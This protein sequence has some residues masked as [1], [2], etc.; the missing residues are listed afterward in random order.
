MVKMKNPKSIKVKCPYQDCKYEWDTLSQMKMVSCPSCLRK[1]E[2]NK[3][4]VK[5]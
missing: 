5:E 3:H 4:E 1:I 2:I